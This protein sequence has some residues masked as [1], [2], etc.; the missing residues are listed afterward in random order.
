MN[1]RCLRDMFAEQLHGVREEHD[2]VQGRAPFVGCARSMCRQ[3][4]KAELACHVSQVRSQTGSV[5]AARMPVQD[6]VAVAECTRASHVNLAAAPFFG[7]ATV[8]S[9]GS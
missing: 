4:A 5:F 2:P 3:A 6:R 1:T 7:W 8:E 9:H